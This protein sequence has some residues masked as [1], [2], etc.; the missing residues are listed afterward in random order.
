MAVFDD[1]MRITT[2]EQDHREINPL[3]VKNHDVI[4]YEHH[5]RDQGQE[6]RGAEAGRRGDVYSREQLPVPLHRAKNAE[7]TGGVS[8]RAT[9]QGRSC[10]AA[11]RTAFAP[12]LSND[13]VGIVS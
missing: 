9:A 11:C 10:R 1:I 8:Q 4:T 13:Y 3:P 7:L 2:D 6:A 5:R 12:S